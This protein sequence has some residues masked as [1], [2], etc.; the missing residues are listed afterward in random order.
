MI[1][2]NDCILFAAPNDKSQPLAQVRKGDRIQIQESNGKWAQCQ[3]KNKTGF[4]DT[5][6]LKVRKALAGRSA[7]DFAT[8]DLKVEEDEEVVLAKPP[9]LLTSTNALA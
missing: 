2:P 3:H 7:R 9:Q 5:N 6:L 1:A 8:L 4:V